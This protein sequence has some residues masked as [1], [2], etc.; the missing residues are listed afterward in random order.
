M[1]G[2]SDVG[3]DVRDLKKKLRRKEKK[4]T[5]LEAKLRTWRALAKTLME[6]LNKKVH[7]EAN[8]PMMPPNY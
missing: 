4:I 6:Q 7:Q 8:R 1:Y 2:L 3:D 5:Q